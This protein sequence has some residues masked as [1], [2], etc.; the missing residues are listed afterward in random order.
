MIRAGSIKAHPGKP[1]VH[2]RHMAALAADPATLRAITF[3]F[4]HMFIFLFASGAALVPCSEVLMGVHRPAAPLANY[5]EL[6]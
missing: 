2:P 1:R 3:I 6:S 4:F 5:T